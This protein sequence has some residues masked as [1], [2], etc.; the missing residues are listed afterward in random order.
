MQK[1]YLDLWH[2]L[3]DFRPMN[4]NAFP[5]DMNVIFYSVT[6]ITWSYYV[7]ENHTHF[8]QKTN[9]SISEVIKG[10]SKQT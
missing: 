8:L 1:H 4:V 9:A 7:T 3:E 2:P 5:E 10:T 6:D